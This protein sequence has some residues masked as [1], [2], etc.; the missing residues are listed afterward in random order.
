MLL[1]HRMSLLEPF[2]PSISYILISL[3][4]WHLLLCSGRLFPTLL[5]FRCF[6]QHMD[7]IGEVT[8]VLT[9]KRIMVNV[10]IS[11]FRISR[12]IG[13]ESCL[14]EPN[15]VSMKAH[16]IDLRQDFQTTIKHAPIHPPST[17]SFTYSFIKYL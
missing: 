9:L 16:S 5:F 13:D 10:K 17:Y 7:V 2:C 6:Y 1:I 3:P 4:N 11:S 8:W 14:C 12:D 15:K